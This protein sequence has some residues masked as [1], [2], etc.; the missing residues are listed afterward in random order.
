MILFVKPNTDFT[1]SDQQIIEANSTIRD[2]EPSLI[3]IYQPITGQ[4][5]TS[6][7]PYKV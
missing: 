4:K 5:T 7:V 6:L 3:T 1:T 2:K